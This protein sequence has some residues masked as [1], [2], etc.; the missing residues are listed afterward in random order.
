MEE[1]AITVSQLSTY[2]K[3]IFDA[4][5]L[6]FNIKVI[7]EVSGLSIV[8][9]VAYFILKDENAMLSCVC[10]N[11]DYFDFKNGDNVVVTGSPKYYVKGGKLNFNVSKVVKSGIGELYQ[12]FLELKQ[13][14]EQKG[15]FEESKKKNL[16][17]IINRIGVVTSK[18]GAVIQDI[19]NV[20]TRRNP[21][22]DIVLYPAKV[23]GV[24]AEYEIAEGIKFLEQYNVDLI[25]VARGGGSLED[26][27]PFNTKVVADAI[28]NCNKFI[29]SAVGH[30]T[31]FTICDF[32]SDL[33]APTPSAA[34]EL[35]CEN[36][37]DKLQKFNL[38]LQKLKDATKNLY[39]SKQDE[40]ITEV[41]KIKTLYQTQNEFMFENLKRLSVNLSYTVKTY[42]S[43]KEYEYNLLNSKLLKLN[44]SE[45]L[46]LGYA[47]LKIKGK[48]VSSVTEMK[49]GDCLTVVL[50]DGIV[51]TTIDK[52]EG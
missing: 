40:L 52:I 14:L 16:P 19:I 34:A 20:R 22:I 25:I 36:I 43:K 9:G 10:F 45:I 6:L 28:F 4:E 30:E 50:N 51:N 12:K 18:E 2:I 13:E 31:D 8:R 27:Q 32:C 46:K 11:A 44:P 33:R 17:S 15:Y 21:Y 24:N 41:K 35:V 5:E 29:L 1:K 26:L 38:C 47:S 37:G 42:L 3:Q 49:K 39:I 23:Q 7:G 48:T